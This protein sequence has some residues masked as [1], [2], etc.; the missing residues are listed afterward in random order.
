[1]IR[2]VS[3][4]LCGTA[5]ECLY[6]PRTF[7]LNNNNSNIYSFHLQGIFPI[8]KLAGIEMSQFCSYGG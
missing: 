1:M 5:T 6:Q 3:G 2:L 7:P 8:E 4:S